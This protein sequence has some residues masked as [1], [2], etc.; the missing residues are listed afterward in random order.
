MRP[1]R[2][3]RLVRQSLR[4]HRTHFVLSSVG[5]VIGVATLI[6][7]TALGVGV[8]QTVLEEIF[9][10]GQIEV[11]DPAGGV[12]SLFGA[13]RSGL[14][15][16]DVADL[17]ALEGVAA[18]YPKMK[19]TMPSSA[20]GGG[21]LMGRDIAIEFVGDGI[22]TEL[23]K[24]GAD[25]LGFADF[26]APRSCTGS[27]ECFDGQEC[28]EGTCAYRSCQVGG[29]AEQCGQNGYCDREEGVCALPIPV[30]ASPTLLELYNGSVHTALQGSEGMGSRLPRLTEEM[31][32]GFEF[33]IVF[34]Q[35]YMGRIPEEAPNRKRARLV[36]FSDRA[37]AIGATMPIGYVERMNRQ[38]SGEEAG[39]T[40]HSILVEAVSNDRVAPLMQAIEEELGL[41]LS[42]RH[43]QAER[44]GV[45]ILLLT[46]L[47]NLIAVLILAISALNI[48]HTFSMMVV[49][50]R[51][52][53]GLMR[54]VGAR[55]RDLRALFLGEA[56]VVGLTAGVMGFV[57]AWAVMG[58]V[59][60]L[61]ASQVGDFPF[62]PE[63]LFV[64]QAWMVAMGL[65]TALL[66][67][68]LGALLPA[69]KAA[70]V[71]PS[72]ALKAG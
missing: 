46:M 5:I 19:L 53:I 7:F 67:S 2:Y 4:R 21:S 68:W 36:G 38:F 52:E 57:V 1:G 22:P 10:I 23:V 45:L 18:A 11:V 47:F 17:E 64:V 49:K 3:L 25:S 54:A 61:F 24:E 63:S 70:R 69:M 65:V 28:R 42:D 27:E 32:V 39:E 8:R 72:E 51:A 33:D 44:A 9:V 14:T 55:R 59:D 16:R 26:E 34:G 35:S 12:G 50:R 6:F 71:E 58:G 41:G 40:Y 15:D 43:R 31:L 48:T 66:F 60:A 20:R 62:K 13:G 56:S 30:L 37:M 29:G